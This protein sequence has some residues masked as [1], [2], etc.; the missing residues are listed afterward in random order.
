MATKN[1][2]PSICTLP[3][4]LIY[5]ILD[6]LDNETILFSFGYTCKR[7]QTIIHTYKQYKLNFKLISK[8]YFHLICHS[9]HPENII[10]LTLSNNKQTPDQIKCF[11]SIFSIQQFIRLRSLTLN[12]I[13][14]DDFYTIFQFKNTISSLSFTFL[15]STLQNSQ[16]ISLLSS[17]ISNKNLR[18]LDFNLSPKDLLWSNQ[19]LLQTLIISNT[20]NFTQFSTIISNLLLLKKFVLQDC[21]IHKNDIIDCSIRYLP[22]IS[23]SFN[24]SKLNMDNCE[25]LLCLFPLLEHFHIVGGDYFFD[26][27]R[28][29][30]LIQKN[31]LKL[32]KFEFAFCGNTSMLWTNSNDIESLITPF[33]TPFWIEYKQWFV[34]CCYFID[35]TNYT[36]YSLPI[37]KSNN[38]L[39]QNPFF[40]KL[41]ALSLCVENEWPTGSTEYLSTFI[42]LS[43]IRELSISI[44]LENEYVLDKLTNIKN[45]LNQLYNLQSLRIDNCLTSAE[46][47]RL[48]VPNHV[49]YLRTVVPDIDDMKFIIE[50]LTHLSSI[51]FEIFGK[52]KY[53]LEDF[54]TWLME[55]RIN[56]TYRYDDQ[57]LSMWLGK[58]NN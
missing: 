36:L 54:L 31:L 40:R 14:E 37:C 22:L 45:L 15:K 27:F 39:A 8:R 43:F 28:W 9:I 58:I 47:I 4:E 3:V 30:K 23:L 41:N 38:I 7:F 11:L 51:T 48:L 13:D 25:L 29:E 33:R 44:D 5:R 20:L 24:D 50:Q 46:I 16:T 55:T 32:K 1:H 18:Y 42:N 2:T 49:K 34:V 57:F 26:G 52:M 21:I 17:I 19:C 12:K 6:T 53:F 10:S 56:S 35:T